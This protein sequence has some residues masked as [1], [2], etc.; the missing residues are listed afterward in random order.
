MST[1]STSEVENIAKLARLRFSDAQKQKLT[2]ELSQILDYVGQL[3]GMP[4]EQAIDPISALDPDEIN[5]TRDDVAEP[6][7]DP[8]AFLK[9]APSTEGGFVKVKSILE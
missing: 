4:L 2:D 8:E 6:V 7:F 3:Q 5:L 9:Q 1:I